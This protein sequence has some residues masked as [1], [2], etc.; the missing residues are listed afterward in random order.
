MKKKTRKLIED[1]V[2]VAQAIKVFG[3]E[4]FVSRPIGEYEVWENGKW[5]KKQEFLTTKPIKG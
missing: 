5:V 3:I 2:V 1:I 4:S